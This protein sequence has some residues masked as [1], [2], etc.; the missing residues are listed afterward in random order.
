[1]N[2]I[3]THRIEIY[4]S[5]LLIGGSYDLTLYRRVSDA[6]NGEQRRFIPLRD[7][8]VAPLSRAQSAQRVPQL[9]VD[10]SEALMV[11]TVEEASPP[12][13]YPREEQLR[14]VEAVATMFF[15]EAFV[16][17]AMFYKRPHLSLPDALELI[18]DDFL[19]LRDVHVY[20]LV[21]GFTPLTRDFAALSRGRIVALYPLTEAPTTPAPYPPAPP[22]LRPEPLEEPALP[23]QELPGQETG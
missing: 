11:A 22:E 5:S 10:R 19:P 4:T 17:R 7:A 16:V 6:F 21:G 23:Q 15:T 8:T 3:Y 13:D 20:P 12:P 2:D 1:M 14:G 9:L 18:T